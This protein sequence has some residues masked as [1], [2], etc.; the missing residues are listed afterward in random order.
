MTLGLLSDELEVGASVCV[1]GGVWG[2]VAG[3]GH[4]GGGDHTGD[5]AS[6]MTISV[7]Q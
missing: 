3:R 6:C 5:K 7:S 2:Q 4:H 1:L